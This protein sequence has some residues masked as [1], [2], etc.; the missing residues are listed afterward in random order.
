MRS[1]SAL[2][3]NK[4]LQLKNLNTDSQRLILQ[5]KKSAFTRIDT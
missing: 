3:P 1:E 5:P 2:K 4:Q